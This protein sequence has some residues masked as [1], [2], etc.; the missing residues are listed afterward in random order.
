MDAMYQ[1]HYK[2]HVAECEGRTL[3]SVDVPVEQWDQIR[4]DHPC[5]RSGWYAY[6]YTCS[7]AIDGAHMYAKRGYDAYQEI[8]AGYGCNAAWDWD[9]YAD[10][11][12]E[13]YGGELQ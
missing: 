6:C 5:Y 13:A 9:G 12:R 4:R 11:Y 7:R 10:D 3:A 1:Q 2:I 8:E